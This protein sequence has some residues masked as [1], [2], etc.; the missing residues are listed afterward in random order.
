M[1]DEFYLKFGIDSDQVR[2]SFLKH[3]LRGSS[4]YAEIQKLVRTKLDETYR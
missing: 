2:A 4:E 1:M 3:E